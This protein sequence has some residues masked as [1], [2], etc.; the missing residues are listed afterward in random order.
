MSKWKWKAFPISIS[1]MTKSNIPTFTIK[2]AKPHI[3]RIFAVIWTTTPWTLPSNQAIS[4]NEKLRY[5]FVKRTD[6]SDPNI[7][8]VANDLLN[9]FLAIINC[10]CQV[11][12]VHPGNV[13]AGATYVHPVYKSKEGTFVHADHVSASKGTGLVHTAPAHGHDDFLVALKHKIPIVGVL[14]QQTLEIT[15]YIF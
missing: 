9:S 4:Y 10:K 5:A 8:I 2:K 7:Y 1:L 6:Y 14:K 13:L 12:G 15:R 3:F 11:L